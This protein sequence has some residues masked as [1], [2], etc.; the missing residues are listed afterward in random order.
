[1]KPVLLMM[2][3]IRAEREGDWLLHLATF[4]KMLPY[5]FA[6]RHVNYARY[7]LYYLRS[8]EKLPDQVQSLFLKGQHVTRHIRGIWNGI[9]SDQFIESTF[10]RY[11]HS[12]GGIT[13]ITLKS[14]ALKVWALSRHI[15]CK[16]ESDMMEL[17]EE[18]T[19]ATRLQRH[20]KEES[21]ARILADATDRAGLRQKLET[22][23]D[24][25][26]PKEHPEGSL[27]NIVSRKLAPASVNVENAVM[28]GEAMLKDFENTWPEGFYSTISKTVETMSVASKSVNIGDTKVYDLNAIYSRVIALLASDRDVDVK[29][30]FAYELAP[31]PT[32]MFTKD[33]MRIAKAKSKLKK[34][35]QVEVS[36]RNT[37]DADVTIIDGSSPFM[38]HTLASRWYSS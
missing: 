27:V 11:G 35:L 9:W 34:L 1:M 17:E 29:E 38:D 3:Y 19:D 10:M 22:C 30:V 25:M 24:P 18:E 4:R 14:I 5:Y 8:M 13:G 16:I 26:D 6:A 20:H 31:V 36:R 7:G 2:S 21:K 32:A 15:C 28:I 37:G 23:T 33:G 12:A